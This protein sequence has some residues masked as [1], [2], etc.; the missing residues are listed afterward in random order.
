MASAGARRSS[1]SLISSSG[2]EAPAVS[3]TT[4][5]MLSGSSEARFTRY[6]FSQPSSRA[7]FSSA[8]VLEELAEPTMMTAPHSSAIAVSAAC[9]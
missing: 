4:P 5:V 6:T 2:A 8:R 7:S 1:T 3:P 9:R